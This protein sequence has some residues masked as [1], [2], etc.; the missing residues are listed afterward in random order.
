MHAVKYECMSYELCV[1][2]ESEHAEQQLVLGV[3]ELVDIE[4]Y[5]AQKFNQYR[6]TLDNQYRYARKFSRNSEIL[7]TQTSDLSF[8]VSRLS[9]DNRRLN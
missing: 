1:F 2:L 5:D 8:L 9:L 4:E 3:V 6:Y 7:H